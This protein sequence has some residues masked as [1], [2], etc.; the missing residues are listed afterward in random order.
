MVIDMKDKD[1]AINLLKASFACS[2]A[3]LTYTGTH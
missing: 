3:K 1:E 2:F